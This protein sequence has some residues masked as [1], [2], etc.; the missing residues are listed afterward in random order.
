[1]DNKSDYR[2]LIVQAR[3]DA[4]RQYYG[5]EMRKEY[6]KLYKIAS[7]LKKMMDYI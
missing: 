7:M 5:E 4:N 1:M 3:I 6:S 2:L